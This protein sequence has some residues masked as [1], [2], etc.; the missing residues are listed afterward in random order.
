MSEFREPADVVEYEGDVISGADYNS[1]EYT[2]N[3]V[4]AFDDVSEH[5]VRAAESIVEVRQHDISSTEST[6]ISAAERAYDVAAEQVEK[7]REQ[8]MD[9]KAAWYE[10]DPTGKIQ[11]DFHDEERLR[12]DALNHEQAERIRLET[13]NAKVAAINQIL[14]PKARDLAMIELLAEERARQERKSRW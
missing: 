10:A 6:V 4:D 5:A 9:A 3:P 11:K 1:I 12:Q 8:G 14:D 13:H 7:R 2:L